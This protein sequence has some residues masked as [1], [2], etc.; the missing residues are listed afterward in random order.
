MRLAPV[1]LV[2]LLLTTVGAGCTNQAPAESVSPSTAVK[3]VSDPAESFSNQPTTTPMATYTYQGQLP[4]SEITNK[5]VRIT[6]EKG[7]IVIAL[8][9]DT[10]PLTVSNF[11]SLAGKGFYDGTIFHR[12]IKDFMIQG[13]DPTGTG[14]GGPG[15]QFKDELKDK[16]TYVRGTVAM[17]NSG[18]DTNGSQFFI[19][20]ADVPLPHAYSIFGEVISGMDVVDALASTTVDG[21]D[22]PLKE[23]KMTKVTVEDAK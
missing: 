15:Y 5:V 12:I 18:P 11:V 10:A 4:E 16:H 22:R 19:M 8:Y 7:D 13:G 2:V 21:S 6:T 3:G 23:Q 20:H 1:A 17:A 14:M 9:P